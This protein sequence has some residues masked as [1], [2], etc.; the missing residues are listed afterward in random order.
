MCT[1]IYINN[2]FLLYIYDTIEIVFYYY[3]LLY[4]IEFLL[5]IYMVYIYFFL[6]YTFIFFRKKQS[7]DI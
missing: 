2:T 1:H 4:I 6:L 3:I 7:G 5:Y